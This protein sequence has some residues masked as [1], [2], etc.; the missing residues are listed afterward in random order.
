MNSASAAESE[1]LRAYVD[2]YV[3]DTGLSEA[4]A[5]VGYV[6]LPSERIDATRAAWE[7]AAV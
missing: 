2:L 4:V 1:A 6:P 5:A 7:G 3:S